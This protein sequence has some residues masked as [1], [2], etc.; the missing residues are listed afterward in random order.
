MWSLRK[1]PGLS[2]MRA[3]FRNAGVMVFVLLGS[4]NVAFADSPPAAKGAPDTL[5]GLQ[6]NVADTANNILKIVLVVVTIA[7]ILLV[8]RG[9]VHL[10]QNYTGT[11]QEKHLGKGLACL[12]FGTALFIAVPITHA[13]VGSVSGTA[14]T[15][16][17]AWTS[18]NAAESIG[19]AS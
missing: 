6:G 2:K 1:L 16:Y 9:I 11:G 15:T 14:S 13:L 5:A 12:G 3:C 7:G 17:N 4:L 10:K 8:I 19:T 18:A